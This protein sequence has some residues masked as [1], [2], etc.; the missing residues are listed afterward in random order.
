MPLSVSLPAFFGVSEK[1][2]SDLAQYLL[3]RARRRPLLSWEKRDKGYT[4][5]SERTLF[6][7]LTTLKYE[8]C[9]V[10]ESIKFKLRPSIDEIVAIITINLI[11]GDKG[12]ALQVAKDVL[13]CVNF[14]YWVSFVEPTH[15]GQPHYNLLIRLRRKHLENFE[16]ALHELHLELFQDEG[17][18]GIVD[19]GLCDSGSWY[20]HEEGHWPWPLGYSSKYA[21]N[22]DKLLS[23]MTWVKGQG[24]RWYAESKKCI[25]VDSPYGYVPSLDVQNSSTIST[26]DISITPPIDPIDNIA[27]ALAPIDPIDEAE[28]RLNRNAEI[29]EEALESCLYQHYDDEIIIERKISRKQVAAIIQCFPLL[30][31]GI[32]N[33]DL[34]ISR[35]LKLE[36]IPLFEK[37]IAAYRIS[38]FG[39]MAEIYYEIECLRQKL[40]DDIAELEARNL[41]DAISQSKF[42]K[43]CIHDF[44]AIVGKNGTLSLFMEDDPEFCEAVEDAFLRRDIGVLS[45]ANALR[46]K[47][48]DD[49]AEVIRLIPSKAKKQAWAKLY[50]LCDSLDKLRRSNSTVAA[51][52]DLAAMSSEQRKHVYNLDKKSVMIFDNESIRCVVRE[53]EKHIIAWDGKSTRKKKDIDRLLSELSKHDH[54]LK[55]VKIAGAINSYI[56]SQHFDDSDPI[57]KDLRR[58][59]RFH[60]KLTSQ[61]HWFGID[62]SKCSNEKIMQRLRGT[63]LRLDKTRADHGEQ[64]FVPGRIVWD[65][66]DSEVSSR[67]RTKSERDLEIACAAERATRRRES[68]SGRFFQ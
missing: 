23:F 44:P 8:N 7:A 28:A 32:N 2:L 56:E 10:L 62:L 30:K 64:S 49:Q 5:P 24:G 45:L 25:R 48:L 13:K 60:R 3:A 9:K 34:M 66:D 43:E 38:D 31:S 1:L 16:K 33:E 19:L 37:W 36:Y 21:Y 47:A 20:N 58:T 29:D 51:A 52:M 41:A 67:K 61:A 54:C 55:Y 35:N 26:C 4:C 50:R 59:L 12:K 57:F 46:Q 53:I 6:D 39:L 18:A 42:A 65:T 11:D 22:L 14:R 40:V 15:D 68:A 63:D 27:Y 17:F